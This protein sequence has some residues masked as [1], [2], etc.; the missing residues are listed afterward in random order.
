LSIVLDLL[1]KSGDVEMLTDNA[2][3]ST[4]YDSKGNVYTL[5]KATGVVT[6]VNAKGQPIPLSPDKLP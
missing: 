6:G 1:A 5:T 4:F 3:T 2:L